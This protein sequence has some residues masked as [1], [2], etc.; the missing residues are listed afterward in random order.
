M[1]SIRKSDF[2]SSSTI[3]RHTMTD[4]SQFVPKMDKV[5]SFRMGN[6]VGMRIQK[7]KDKYFLWLCKEY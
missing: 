6:T 3:Y 5:I 1:A 4:L 2:L 7:F